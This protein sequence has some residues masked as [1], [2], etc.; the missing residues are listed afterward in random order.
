MSYQIQHS[1]YGP[2]IEQARLFD[3]FRSP[4][5][6]SVFEPLTAGFQLWCNPNNKPGGKEWESV[7]FDRG[8]TAQDCSYV[9]TILWGWNKDSEN[10]LIT[11]LELLTIAYALEKVYRHRLSAG[12]SDGHVAR[13]PATEMNG[14]ITNRPA[15][16]EWAKEKTYWLF[17]LAGVPIPDGGFIIKGE[18]TAND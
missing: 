7:E 5:P 12:I 3:V 2:V 14:L 11:H 4:A 13:I 18:T 10:P 15:D 9:G 6:N 1:I 17:S 8:R 16:V